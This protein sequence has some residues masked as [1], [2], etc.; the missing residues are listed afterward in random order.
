[1]EWLWLPS[2]FVEITP[3]FLVLTSVF[4]NTSWF[5]NIAS[6]KFCFFKKDNKT[7]KR[8]QVEH[9]M[10]NCINKYRLQTS[11]T[12]FKYNRRPNYNGGYSNDV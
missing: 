8:L 6:T 10:L 11:E 4:I 5:Y 2:L 7:L 3:N 9:S 1:M 12:T